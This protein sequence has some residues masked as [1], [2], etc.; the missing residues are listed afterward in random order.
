MKNINQL[1]NLEGKVACVTGA[2][3]N[4]GKSICETIL[5]AKGSLIM[6]DNN[7]ESLQSNLREHQKNYDSEIVSFCSDLSDSQERK[8]LLEKINKTERVDILINCA[9]FVGD[10]ELQG[11]TSSFSEQDPDQQQIRP[12]GT[13]R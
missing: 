13:S 11:W 5:E 8:H 2:S 9:A 7:S 3:G 1:S 6:I 12:A 10:S 4:I